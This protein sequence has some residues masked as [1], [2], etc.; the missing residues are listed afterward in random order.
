MS[1]HWDVIIVGARC[2]GATLA[3][4]LARQGVRTLLLEASSRGSNQP[5]STHL[6]QSPGMAVLDRLGL[7]QRVREVTPASARLRFALDQSS[8][9]TTAA[10]ERAARCVRRSTLDPWLQDTAEA[11]GAELR[12]RHR[13]VDLVRT[14]ERVSG[15]VVSTST[16]TT[17]LHADLVIGA[18]GP[19]ST[20]AACSGAEEYLVTESSRAGYWTYYDAPQ[21]WEHA[22]DAMLEHR[23]DEVRYVFR[24]DGGQ[25]AVVY[26]APRA[27]I[28]RWGKDRRQ[29]LEHAFAA[30]ETTRVLTEGKRPVAPLMGFLHGKFFYRRPVGPGFGLIGDAGH[31]KD[32]VTGQGMTDAFLDAER[33]AEAIV[34]G[35]DEAFAHYWRARD[36]ATLPLHFDAIRQGRVGYNEPFIRWVVARMGQSP[37]LSARPQLVFDRRIGP[38]EMIPTGTLLAMVGSALLRGRFH[39]ARGFLAT[40]KQLG[41]EAR[42]LEQR[43]ALLAD[44]AARL[45][46]A[47]PRA[48]SEGQRRAA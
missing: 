4:L 48:A 3:T 24:C 45:E 1:E 47:A 37:A 13:V 9:I 39:V 34:D 27:L 44:A 36:V 43:Q 42:E 46:H 8:L 33:M 11:A 22:W 38:A 23:G 10:E 19:Q 5:M 12:F 31:F 20:V 28:E 7:G 18:D 16:A 14:N 6:V 40:G 30:S 26:M 41:A 35:R 32:F 29:H 21:T 17:T 2:A 15:V 25:I